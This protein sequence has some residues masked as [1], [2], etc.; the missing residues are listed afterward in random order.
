MRDAVATPTEA[1]VGDMHGWLAARA[2]WLR[3]RAIPM[4]VAS[5]G[6]LAV[7]A[8]ASYLGNMNRGN[9]AATHA[10]ASSANRITLEPAAAFTIRIR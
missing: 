8:S 7:L 2:A 5:L 9:V 10:Q 4:I 6:M 3:P 1:L